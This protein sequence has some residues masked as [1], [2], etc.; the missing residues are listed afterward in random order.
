MLLLVSVNVR[1]VQEAS[2]SLVAFVLSYFLWLLM[3]PQKDTF[4]S[5]QCI[6]NFLF[7]VDET[8]TVRDTDR[9]L[10]Q[11]LKYYM[12]APPLLS[13]LVVNVTD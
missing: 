6:T 9:F 2:L 13:F 1:N 12:I 11:C 7:I 5:I 3:N 8:D 10:Y 4:V